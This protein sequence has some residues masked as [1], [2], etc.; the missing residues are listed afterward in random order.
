MK[1]LFPCAEFPT[2]F[3]LIKA[4]LTVRRHPGNRFFTPC[5]YSAFLPFLHSI[6]TSVLNDDLGEARH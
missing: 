1:I 5:Y 2:A 3:C 4:V 6:L